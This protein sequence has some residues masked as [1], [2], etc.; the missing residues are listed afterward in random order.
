MNTVRLCWGDP[1]YL[2]R[3]FDHWTVPEAV[4]RINRCVAIA[5]RLGMNVVINYH[6]TGEKTAIARGGNPN[7]KPADLGRNQ[8]LRIDFW[9]RVARQH[10][11]NPRVIFE[12]S[13]E[14]LFSL[15]GYLNSTFKNN[16]LAVY[17]RVRAEAP[18]R[19]ILLFSFN[20]LAIDMKRIADDYGPRVDWSKTSIAYHGYLSETPRRAVE[21]A[22]SYRVLCTEWFY[23]GEGDYV[24]EIDGE[25]LVA[26]TMERIGH[27]W[28][29]WRDWSDAHFDRI[30]DILLPDAQAKGYAW[31]ADADPRPQAALAPS[32][33]HR[34][35]C[36]W[37]G[38]YLLGNPNA[39]QVT[40]QAPLN[41]EWY[42]QRWNLEPVAG[43]P[44]RV[45][46]KCLW[47]NVYLS[48]TGR[49]WADTVH[50]PLN[51]NDAT[52]VWAVEKVADTARTYRLRSVSGGNHLTGRNV[53]F[54]TTREAPLNLAWYSQ[55]WDL[56]PLD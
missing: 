35:K 56:E 49:N 33:V 12:I 31:E 14:P 50:K 41:P 39:G 16:L 15:S 17:D 8:A 25:T 34:L 52:L 10:Q 27:G 20:S 7:Y 45:R 24:R 55:R 53:N 19:Q 48:A 43:Q 46:L 40:K 6:N 32:G 21:A 36:G 5:D 18:D 29:D 38:L 44:G 54:S 42:S 26:Q 37:G 2:A 4:G 11:N 22:R 51:T 9:T 28:I 3:D 23:P 47:G 30:T 13:N 1:W